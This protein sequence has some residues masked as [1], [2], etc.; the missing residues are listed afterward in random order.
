MAVK[1]L[2][3]VTNDL[4]VLDITVSCKVDDNHPH[5][6]SPGTYYEWNFSPDNEFGT[7]PLFSN[8][9]F[10]WERGHYH[11]FDLYVEVR[12]GDCSKCLWLIKPD[13]PCWSFDSEISQESTQFNM[14]GDT[15]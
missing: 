3:R 4:G 6:L 7:E 2:I 9:S 8:C 5:V 1:A 13:S 11:T 12:D 10:Q 15:V 14:Q